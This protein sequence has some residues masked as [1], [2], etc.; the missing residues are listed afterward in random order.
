MDKLHIPNIEMCNARNL[1]L[2]VKDTQK[3]TR[4]HLQKVLIIDILVAGINVAIHQRS[5]LGKPQADLQHV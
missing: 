2:L 3:K 4:N 1:C 5:E